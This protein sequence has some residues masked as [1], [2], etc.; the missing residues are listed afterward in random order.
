MSA[1]S[2]APPVPIKL[3]VKSNPIPLGQPKLHH[4]PN[5]GALSDA[6]RLQVIRSIAMQRGRD[7]RIITQAVDII[8]ASGAQP[9]EYKRQAAALLKWV[10]NPKNVYYINVKPFWYSLPF[11]VMSERYYDLKAAD[12][13]GA[14]SKADF[15]KKMNEYTSMY[16]FSVMEKSDAEKKVDEIVGEKIMSHLEEFFAEKPVVKPHP[17]TIRRQLTAAEKTKLGRPRHP[18]D[19]PHQNTQPLPRRVRNRRADSRILPRQPSAK[20]IAHHPGRN[21]L[22]NR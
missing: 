7:P 21:G 2:P 5:W 16:K 15:V 3:P 10:Q 4:I 13:V 6:Q 19:R 18:A 22:R 20:R 1:A 14:G 17:K 11:S 12:L 9:R 8:R